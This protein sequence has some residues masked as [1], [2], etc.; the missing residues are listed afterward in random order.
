MAVIPFGK[1]ALLAQQTW[2]EAGYDVFHPELIDFLKN[3]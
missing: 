1:A 2:P 3:P